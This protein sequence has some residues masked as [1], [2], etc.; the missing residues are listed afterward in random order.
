MYQVD[1]YYK[2]EHPAILSQYA[3]PR[4]CI[5]ILNFLALFIIISQWIFLAQMPRLLLELFQAF[6]IHHILWQ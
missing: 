1:N 3:F 6:G 2:G 5:Q 4:Y